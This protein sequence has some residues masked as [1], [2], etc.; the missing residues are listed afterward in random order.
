MSTCL[1]FSELLQAFFTD[2][3]MHQRQASPNTIASY[4]DTFRLLLQFA[5][6][7]TGKPPT[8]LTMELLEPGFLATF[9]NHLEVERGICPRSRN[10]RLAAIHSFF[11]FVAFAEPSYLALAQ[12]VLAMP[13]K[14]FDQRPIEYLTRPEIEALL[15]APDR[16]TWG[17]RRDYTL[18][19]VA[20]QTGLRISELIGLRCDDVVL[21]TGG[22]VRCQ[23][24]GRKERSTPLRKDV[25]VALRGWLRERLG[26]PA[27]PLFP[28]A[29]S[30]PLSRDGA[31]RILAKHVAR[32]RIQCPSLTKKR[33]S[34][35]VLR[36]SVAMDLL[37][38]GVDRSVIALW[39]GHE[40]IETT[41]VYLHASMAMKEKALAKA[42]SSKTRN[43]RYRPNDRLL[44]F[45]KSL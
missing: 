24:K 6:Q 3:L 40:S 25:V 26:G 36:H 31:E 7:Q 34:M 15:S 27:D 19:L 9:L 13:N 32:A 44:A 37:Q 23:G 21:G 1:Q 11:R 28:S 29:R 18:L 20:A 42:S 2:R 41:E 43:V 16:A 10:V 17:G 5:Q 30:G 4:R 39:L 22:S 38:Q 12:R 8:K 35:H 14:R 33:I 45:L